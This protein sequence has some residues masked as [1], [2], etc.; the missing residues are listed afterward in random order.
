M[1][2]GETKRMFRGN[3]TVAQ[4]PPY[5]TLNASTSL[6]SNALDSADRLV[7]LALN[8]STILFNQVSSNSQ[9]HSSPRQDSR[10]PPIRPLRLKRRRLPVLPQRPPDLHRRQHR[11]QH[12]QQTILRQ[13]P[14][15]TNPTFLSAHPSTPPKTTQSLTS[16]RTQ[17][18]PPASAPRC[19]PPLCS[20]TSR[21]RT[22]RALYTPS[23]HDTWPKRSGRQS[24][25]WG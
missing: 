24:C 17:N 23:H 14:P 21:A 8:G 25:P 13:V 2:G 18:S 3:D 12:N 9:H 11:R 6:S 5:E 16:S 1:S 7:T 19:P 10:L 20:S 4:D 15:D 22:A